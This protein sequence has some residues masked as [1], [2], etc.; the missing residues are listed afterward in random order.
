MKKK[1][2]KR[3][4]NKKVKKNQKYTCSQCGAVVTVDECGCSETMNLSCCGEQMTVA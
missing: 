2:A 1:T 3:K 4:S